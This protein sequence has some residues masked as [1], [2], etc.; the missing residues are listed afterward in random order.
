MN[1]ETK[2]ADKIKESFIRAFIKM[3][4]FGFLETLDDIL[5]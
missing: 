5:T 2:W 3:L 1:K 4:P